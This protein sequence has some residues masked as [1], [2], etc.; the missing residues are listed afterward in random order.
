LLEEVED[1]ADV[2]MG[3]LARQL[4]LA[5]EPMVGPFVGGNLRTDRL[6]RDTFAERQILGL[7]QLTH[8]AADDESHNAEAVAENNRSYVGSRRLP[9]LNR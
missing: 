5:E 2:G 1:A 3:D 7:V 9:F 8:A 4:D 6:E